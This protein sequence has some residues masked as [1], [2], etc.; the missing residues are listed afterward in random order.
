MEYKDFY[1]DILTESIDIDPSKSIYDPNNRS[2]VYPFVVDTWKYTIEFSPTTTLKNGIVGVFK[3]KNGPNRPK[4]EDHNNMKSYMFAIDDS[5]MGDV[6]GN[7]NFLKVLSIVLNTFIDYIN[8]EQPELFVFHA[9]NEKRARLYERVCK[10]IEKHTGY[11]M[12]SKTDPMGIT[13]FHFVKNKEAM[14]ESIA[15]FEKPFDGET[16]F[17]EWMVNECYVGRYK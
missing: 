2:R 3:L 11:K 13:E 1:E 9:R 10:L 7:S 12:N 8:K 6:G 17:V 5:E 16:T 15:Y 14:N 4:W